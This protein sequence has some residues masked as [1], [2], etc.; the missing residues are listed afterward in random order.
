VEAPQPETTVTWSGFDD[1][2]VKAQV[3]EGQ[4]VLVQETYD[5]GWHAYENGRALKIR[6]D[7][8][9]SFMVIDIAPGTH[10]IDMKFEVPLENRVGQGLL[11]IALL[12][13]AGLVFLAS[14]E[15]H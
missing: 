15:S 5:S 8:A 7:P 9:M 12:S 3:R 2:Q 6:R 11:A 4:S 1:L 10:T 13:V 14:R